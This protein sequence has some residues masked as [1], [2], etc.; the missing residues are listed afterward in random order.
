MILNKIPFLQGP[1]DTV[2]ERL[3]RTMDSMD[4]SWSQKVEPATRE[5]IEA[6]WRL[7]GLEERGQP[8]PAV[9]RLFLESMGRDDNGLLEQE[10]DGFSQPDID[11]LL[12]MYSNP[13]NDELKERN[14]LT[15][16]THWTDATLF[17]KLTGEDDPPVCSDSSGRGLFSGSFEKYLFQM[18]F[19][20]AEQTQFLYHIL[21]GGSPQDVELILAQAE[22]S[23]SEGGGVRALALF[24]DILDGYGI[25]KAW[26]SDAVQYCGVGPELAVRVTG[27]WGLNIALS[28]D[29][30]QVLREAAKGVIGRLGHIMVLKP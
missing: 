18:A 10:W 17:L 11:S 4:R 22:L 5:Q 19:R 24:E 6:L 30:H 20:R 13:R 28:S 12:E 9:Y 8:I 15:F 25:E 1:L 27:T 2:A 16:L 3:C 14:G 21:L 23:P 29:H 7:S 26:F